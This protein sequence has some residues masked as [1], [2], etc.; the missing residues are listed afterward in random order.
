M[1]RLKKAATGRHVRG[2]ERP[3]GS[4]VK[5]SDQPL[6]DAF[7]ANIKSVGGES[8]ICGTLQELLENITTLIRQNGWTHI[9]CPDE[10]INALIKS[11]IPPHSLEV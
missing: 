2:T 6:P 5:V 7:V 11:H 1:E 9:F 4:F 8:V 10:R 3:A